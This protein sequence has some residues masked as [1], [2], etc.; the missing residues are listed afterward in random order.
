MNDNFPNIF[1]DQTMD[2]VFLKL[3]NAQEKC[4]QPHLVNEIGLVIELL[5]KENHRMDH[6]NRVGQ[7]DAF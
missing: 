7:S 2:T 5:I 6:Q 4:K 3:C 1:S